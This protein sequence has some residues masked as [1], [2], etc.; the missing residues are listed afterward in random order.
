MGRSDVQIQRMVKDYYCVFCFF[1]LPSLCDFKFLNHDK[2]LSVASL[3][4]Y[5]RDEPTPIAT[6]GRSLLDADNME[7]SGEPVIAS[8]VW[9]LSPS[10]V[11]GSGNVC[12]DVIEGEED[13]VEKS[14]KF[15][16]TPM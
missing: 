12:S 7:S 16:T 6:E 8:A 11:A 9:D 5:Q 15:A 14:N 13:N 2:Y 4:S 10:E 1:F 3:S